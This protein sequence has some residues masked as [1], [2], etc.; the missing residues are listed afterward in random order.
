ML[1]ILNTI[2]CVGLDWI[3]WNCS[4]KYTRCVFFVTLFT[5]PFN[6]MFYNIIYRSVCQNKFTLSKCHIISKP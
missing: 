5:N 2:L 3:I 1:L 6:P 4:H